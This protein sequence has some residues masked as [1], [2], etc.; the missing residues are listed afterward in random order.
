MLTI[1][2][3]HFKSCR[4]PRKGASTAI[5]T[6]HSQLKGNCAA[7]RC[8]NRWISEA[9]NLGTK[10][11]AVEA[12]AIKEAASR[13]GKMPSEWAREVFL[14]RDVVG[15]HTEMEMHIFTELVGIQMLVMGT[16]EPVL[17][18]QRIPALAAGFVV[19]GVPCS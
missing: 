7:S 3:R 9:G 16:L 1:F 11:T 2:R 5:A 13:A 19:R 12:K 8:G 6:V 15:S 10:L 17:R 18:G 4:S 14:R